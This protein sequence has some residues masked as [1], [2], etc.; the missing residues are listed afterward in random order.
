MRAR[1]DQIDALSLRQRSDLL[2]DAILADVPGTS[3]DLDMTIRLALTD[4]RFTGW[5]IWPASEAVSARVESQLVVD[6]YII[7]HRKANG[8]Q[9]AKVFKLTTLTLQPGTYAAFS[10]RQSF[11]R[12]TTRVYRPGE[13]AIE[14]QVNGTA[15]G[16]ADFT[17]AAETEL[18]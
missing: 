16:R 10:R 9:T 8:S 17:L 6:D 5:M 12:I 15:S 7:H 11:K 1:A 4:T 18:S 13:H 2:K 3:A 14:V